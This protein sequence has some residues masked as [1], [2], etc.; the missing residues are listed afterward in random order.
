M[1]S[2]PLISQSITLQSAR[3]DQT[4]LSKDRVLYSERKTY[5]SSQQDGRNQNFAGEDVYST[6]YTTLAYVPLYLRRQ[7][8]S[9]GS[10]RTPHLQ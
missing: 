8:P 7:P 2:G 4:G 5:Y 9:K 10:V 1:T 6:L 3:P